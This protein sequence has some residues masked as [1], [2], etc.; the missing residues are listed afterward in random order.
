MLKKT[1]SKKSLPKPLMKTLEYNLFYN[2][3]L[4]VLF[5]PI[6]KYSSNP[7]TRYAYSDNIWNTKQI[8]D[9]THMRW[10]FLKLFWKKSFVP[11]SF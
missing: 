11:E 5:L 4:Y 3:S 2:I 7:G 6:C 9:A 10:V 1:V 8:P